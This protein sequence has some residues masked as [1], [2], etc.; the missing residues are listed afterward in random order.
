MLQALMSRGTN[1]PQWSLLH[2]KVEVPEQLDNEF[3]RSVLVG[4]IMCQLSQ[5][6]QADAWFVAA[7]DRTVL[8]EES[9]MV[10]GLVVGNSPLRP[11][12][13]FRTASLLEECLE[14]D[15][16]LHLVRSELIFNLAMAVSRSAAGVKQSVKMRKLSLFSEFVRTSNSYFGAHVKSYEA[17]DLAELVQQDKGLQSNS[18]RR[19]VAELECPGICRH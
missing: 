10:I 15:R 5:Q 16:N 13:H 11:V 9:K 14:D 7:R 2:S 8:F 4:E 3:A 6:V 19:F 1:L 18:S 12:H 17:E